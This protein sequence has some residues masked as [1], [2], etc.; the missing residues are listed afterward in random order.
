MWKYIFYI[1]KIFSL[2]IIFFLASSLGIA[3]QKTDTLALKKS[4]STKTTWK[5]NGFR[6]GI[7]V[8]GLAQ[9]LW[10]VKVQQSWSVN[11]DI[12]W[13]KYLFL[14]D[15][16]LLKNYQT[17]KITYQ[18]QSTI[19]KV[20][21][22][23]NFIHKLLPKEALFF[24][25]QLANA[26]LSE[27]VVG[28]STNLLFGNK[29]T[30]LTNNFSVRWFELQLGLKYTIWKNIYTGY[31]A[32]YKFGAS[33]RGTEEFKAYNLLGFGTPNKSNFGFEYHLGIKF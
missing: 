15:F 32:R 19:W 29:S 14:A 11:G 18:S 17:G 30:D 24:G 8:L 13:R 2:F 16:S 21:V 22:G 26:Q 20:G 23:Y 4:D 28:G 10:S 33:Q 7:D 1:N 6:V 3:Q 25:I 12:Y 9:P 27:Q 31:V 5:P